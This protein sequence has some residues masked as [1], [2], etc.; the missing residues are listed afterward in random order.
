MK[1]F[2]NRVICHIINIS[3]RTPWENFNVRKKEF[4][5]DR[6][7]IYESVDSGTA[8]STIL[9][10]SNQDIRRLCPVRQ[11]TGEDNTV[12]FFWYRPIGNLL[13]FQDV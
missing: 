11:P 1:R 10:T 7:I 8:G 6:Y 12:G 3:P 9:I 4:T 2:R 5:I 13:D